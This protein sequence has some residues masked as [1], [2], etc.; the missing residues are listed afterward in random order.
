VFGDGECCCFGSL[1]LASPG[2]YPHPIIH[3]M[4][5]Q[6][7]TILSSTKPRKEHLSYEWGHGGKNGESTLQ[8]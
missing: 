1:Q 7:L 5:D 6:A 2:V 4:N 8:L 3:G